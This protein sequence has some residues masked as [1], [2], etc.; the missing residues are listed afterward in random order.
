MK[1]S[2]HTIFGQFY[3]LPYIKV[4]YDRTLNGEYEL[5]FGWVNIGMS[6]SFKPKQR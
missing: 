6:L 5:I 1:L 2:K 3:I 4:T